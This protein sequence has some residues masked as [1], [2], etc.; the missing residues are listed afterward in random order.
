M[1]NATLRHSLVTIVKYS[2]LRVW[3]CSLRYPACDAHAPYCHLWPIHLYYIFPHE[4]I[5]DTIFEGGGGEA[6]N[7]KCILI[8]CTTFV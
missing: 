4:L 7:I 2:T 6:L 8:F 5:N 1:C 3:V